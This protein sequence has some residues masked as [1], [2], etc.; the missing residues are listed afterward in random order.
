MENNSTEK[1][2]SSLGNAILRF[3]HERFDLETGK[4]DELET[5]EYMKGAVEFKGPNLWILIFAIIIA[6][7]GLN[8]NSTAV[9]IGA[10]LISPLM[11]PILGIGMSVAINDLDFLKKSF[12]NLMVATLFSVAASTLY[13]SIS[14]LSDAQSELLARTNPTIWDVLIAFFG[15]L[16]GMVAGS[17][18]EK[19]NA[20][21]GVAIATALMPPLCTAGYGLATGN[22]YYFLGAFYLYF[23][24]GVFISLATF[25]IARLLRYPQKEFADTRRQ[26]VVR[27]WI[28]VFVIVT[29]LPSTVLAYRT[30]QRSVF[31]RNA[32]AF[33]AQELVF[34]NTRVISRQL[35]FDP[36][37]PVIEVS[38]FGE[39]ITE[40]LIENCRRQLPNYK[41]DNANLVVFQ[42]YEDNSH[43]LTLT[44][45]L[46]SG[47]VEELY[48]QNEQV[49]RTKD[50]RIQFLER[51]I[52]RLKGAENQS[53]EIGQEIKA[54]Y[55][56]LEAFT[57]NRTLYLRLDSMKQ[58]TTYLALADFKRPLSRSDT[59]KLE[60]WLKTRM[61][62]DK[63]MV[64]IK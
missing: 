55:P 14:P 40:E 22:L 49:M 32:G 38:L 48:K 47:I 25:L 5:I 30:V 53:T 1:E 36:D 52:V 62:S 7:V 34:P 29:I 18:K 16:A 4:A 2:K 31:E 13:F 56:G 17:R 33:I 46:R 19:S 26:K 11:S 8:V 43:E 6:S 3:I 37:Q 28:T 23:I 42:G 44:N 9:I 20:I 64:V 15:G 60:D 63:V 54:L 41:M 24:N 12:K 35:T 51:E 58:D 57:L 21:P 27:S 39:R 10:M 50:E 45:T 61:K 59:R